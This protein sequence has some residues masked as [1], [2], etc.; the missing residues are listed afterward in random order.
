MYALGQMHDGADAILTKE[1]RL[2]LEEQ[3]VI[4]EYA[5]QG[6]AIF[7]GRCAAGALERE[8]VLSVFIRADDAFRKTRIMQE[9][10]IAEK[11]VSGTMAK[12]DRKR[13]H[14]YHM[15]TGKKWDDPGNYQ[16]VLDSGRL[17]TR[18]C[19]EIIKAAWRGAAEPGA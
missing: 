12:F 13:S 2:F 14:Y 3:R 1:D 11:A 19:A 4:R 6:E 15:N 5:M 10:G 16:I 7:I 9:Y 17:G 18:A 8:Y